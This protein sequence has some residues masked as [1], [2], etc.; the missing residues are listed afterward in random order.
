MRTTAALSALLLVLAG[1]HAFAVGAEGEPTVSVSANCAYQ[2]STAETQ[3]DELV[4][5]AAGPN[6][7]PETLTAAEMQQALAELPED[8]MDAA[9]RSCGSLHDW[10]GAH[11]LY[12]EVLGSADAT[13]FV[14]ERCLTAASELE[15]YATCRSVATA[16]ATPAPVVDAV[17]TARAD[18]RPEHENSKPPADASPRS[19]TT[20]ARVNKDFNARIPGATE[21]RY[22]RIRGDTPFKLLAQNQIRSVPHCGKHEAIACVSMSWS[23]DVTKDWDKSTRKCSMQSVGTKLKSIVFL[24]RWADR[25]GADPALVRWWHQV[26]TE[27]AVHEAEHIKI[28]QQHL[29]NF[30][31]EAKGKPCGSATYFY[32]Q[33]A[34]SANLAQAEFDEVEY[35]KPLPPIPLS[36]LE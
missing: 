28:Q 19:R 8:W 3:K 9:I 17:A 26:L 30:R 36:L 16:L 34:A 6:G 14:H 33:H 2:F 32:R 4:K 20:R 22:F 21:V 15:P 12:P 31:A 29:A 5:A 11:Q 25:A 10:L 23:I 7:D 1:G 27:S 35:Q 13:G 24:P 18:P